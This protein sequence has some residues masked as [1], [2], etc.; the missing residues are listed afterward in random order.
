METGNVYS[1]IQEFETRCSRY[2]EMTAVVLLS[3]DKYNLSSVS[4]ADREIPTR[5]L[6]DY[7]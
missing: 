2:R 4:D 3:K 7:A 6:T 5:K 1:L